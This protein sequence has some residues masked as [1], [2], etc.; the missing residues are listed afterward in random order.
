MGLLLPFYRADCVEEMLIADWLERNE[1][2]TQMVY[3]FE[4][5]QNLYGGCRPV[6]HGL[7]API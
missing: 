3:P 5:P 6:D 2:F 1:Q 7:P 4:L